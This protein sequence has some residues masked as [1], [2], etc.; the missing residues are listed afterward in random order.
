M[1]LAVSDYNGDGKLDI[2]S[3]HFQSESNTLYRNLGASGFID[4]TGS[5]GLHTPTLDKRGFGTVMQDLN[6]DGSMRYSSLTGTSTILAPIPTNKC[7][8]N[9]S[10]TKRKKWYD[11]SAASGE[12]FQKSLFPVALHLPI[13]I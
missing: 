6:Q 5:E 10:P 2:Y 11:V 13:S 3:T 4:S 12:W 8:D 1:G 7:Q 9:C